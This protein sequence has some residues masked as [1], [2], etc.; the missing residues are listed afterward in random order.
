MKTPRLRRRHSKRNEGAAMLIIM[1]M[2]LMVTGT[3]VFAIH[4]TGYEMR[5]AGYNRQA[6]Q[7]HYVGESGARAAMAWVDH[8]GPPCVITEAIRRTKAMSSYRALKMAPF[9]P[10][11]APNKDAHR[12]GQRDF[13]GLT[14]APM[15]AASLGRRLAYEPVYVVDIY[16]HFVLSRAS[17][18]L[19]GYDVSTDRGVVNFMNITYTS[20]GRTRNLS[21][22]PDYT[23]PVSGD[24]P[25]HEGSSD[26]RAYTI[27]GPFDACDG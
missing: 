20:R 5:A 17:E 9:E 16:D 3:A 21:S 14:S 13:S 19:A 23:S 27:T 12:I 25:A 1:L 8:Y 6:T 24:R 2:L 10:E 7:T 11:L 26:A 4:A 18:E 22:I 15:S